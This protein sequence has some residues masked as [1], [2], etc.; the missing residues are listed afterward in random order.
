MKHQIDASV[1]LNGNI[2]SL[3]ISS[4]KNNEREEFFQKKKNEG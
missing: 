3:I 1:A 2:M 4:Q